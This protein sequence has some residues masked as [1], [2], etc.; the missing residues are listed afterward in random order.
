MN[1]SEIAVVPEYFERYT[2]LV[3]TEMSL[4]EALDTYGANCISD[5][6]DQYRA[7]GD[8]IYAPGKWTVKQTLVHIADAERVFGYRALRFAR[9]DQSPLI[10]FEQ[11]DFVASADV[12]TR[13]LDEII[14]ELTVV[15]AGTKALYGTFDD[16][17]LKRTGTASG[18]PVSVLALGFMACGHMIHHQQIFRQK[19]F[20]LLS[21]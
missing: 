8:Q 17:V 10:G 20:A 21:S 1:R 7:L 14:E 4:I 2:S 18:K 19:Y 15:R 12:S 11:D 6:I 3:P 9:G 5:D 16:K 13:S